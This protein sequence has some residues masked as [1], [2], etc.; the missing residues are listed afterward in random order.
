MNAVA[1]IDCYKY[2]GDHKSCYVLFITPFLNTS[3]SIGSAN[4]MLAIVFSS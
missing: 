3:V 1:A 2:T 4:I